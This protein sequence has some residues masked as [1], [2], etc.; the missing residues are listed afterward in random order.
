MNKL[1]QA[2][3]IC[4]TLFCTSAMA[5]SPQSGIYWNPAQ[6]G[7]GWS[8]DYQNGSL[9][10]AAYVY[11]A[12]GT[13]VWYLAAAP[14]THGN[15][16]FSGLAQEYAHGQC[17]GCSHEDPVVVGDEG[18]I[19]LVFSDSRN[20]RLTWGGES[21]RIERQNFGFG[22]APASMLGRWAF[23]VPGVFSLDGETYTFRS[24]G[25][26]SGVPGGTGTFY[27]LKQGTIGECYTGGYLAGNCVVVEFS[28][29]FRMN[30]WIFFKDLDR[31]DGLRLITRGNDPAIEQPM[32]G[33]QILA[34]N[35]I[36]DPSFPPD[37][38]TPQELIER[39]L[40]VVAE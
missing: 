22:R 18:T 31:L 19:T 10:V 36:E 29:S 12:D 16:R 14:M 5:F 30:L 8:L 38:A 11:K 2:T 17:L 23:V 40:E 28:E 13:P 27:D 6:P 20:A 21:I 26:P 35:E 37:V 15:T 3:A 9:A 25:P 33:M 34:A 32:N 4:V 24:I 1:M 7:R 39:Y